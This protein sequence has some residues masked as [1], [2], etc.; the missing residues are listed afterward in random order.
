TVTPSSG[1]IA[2]ETDTVSVR[3][4]AAGL[5]AGSY[6][7]NVMITETSQNG[8]IRRTIFPVTLS[9]RGAAAAPAIQ[10]SVSGLTFSGTPGDATPHPQKFS[11]S[12]A[13]GGPL[14]WTASEKAGW[15]THSP[16]SGTT[17]GTVTASIAASGLGAGTYSTTVTVSPPGATAKTLPVTLTIT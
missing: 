16:A 5:A 4:T 11:I 2:T 12:N 17:T 10:L 3:A 7:A 14:A 1:T 15:L 6:S 13:R 8:R 9:V